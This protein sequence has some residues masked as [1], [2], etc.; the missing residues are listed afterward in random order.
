MKKIINTIIAILL[1]AN[2]FASDFEG[3]ISQE[4]FD[5]KNGTYMMQWHIK[6]KQ[7]ALEIIKDEVSYYFIPQNG[8]LLMYASEASVFDGQYYYS[9][10]STSNISANLKDIEASVAEMSK[11]VA[12]YKT[13]SVVVKGDYRGTVYFNSELFT[14]L[15]LSTYFKD[16]Y[17]LNALGLSGVIGIPLYSKI[18]DGNAVVSQVKT[19]KISEVDVPD[20]IFSAPS[21]YINLPVGR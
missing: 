10:V 11:E 5:V 15:D 3:I 19:L 1:F 6:G 8:K 9:V 18:S 16:N 21:N 2:V 14:D 17:E 13:N 20:S 7:L 12:G 4:V